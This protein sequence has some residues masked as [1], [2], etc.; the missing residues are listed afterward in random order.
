MT[1]CR[2]FGHTLVCNGKMT[3]NSKKVSIYNVVVVACLEVLSQN[4]PGEKLMKNTAK[5]K[6]VYIPNTGQ[7]YCCYTNLLLRKGSTKNSL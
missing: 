1:Q 3:M 4:V 5:I 6:T 2:N 7:D